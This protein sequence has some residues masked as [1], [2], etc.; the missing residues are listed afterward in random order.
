MS[1]SAAS[2]PASDW[3]TSIA[4]ASSGRSIR[5]QAFTAASDARSMNSSML[6]SRPH[7]TTRDTASAAAGA[8]ANRAATVRGAWA[9]GRSDRVASVIT[10]SVPSLPMNSLVRSYPATPFAVRRPVRRT[11]PE[12]S[13]TSR[14]ST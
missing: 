7:A 1:A 2:P 11:S 3:A 6:G 8:E 9:A 4:A 13:T 10:P 5:F 12:A 14:P